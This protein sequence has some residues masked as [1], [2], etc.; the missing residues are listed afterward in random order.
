MINGLASEF[1]PD[2]PT[3]IAGEGAGAHLALEVQLNATQEVRS[4]LKGQILVSP[5]LDPDSNDMGAPD[6]Q[7]Q[8]ISRSIIRWCWRQ[9]MPSKSTRDQLLSYPLQRSQLVGLP[10]TLI[11]TA[12]FDPVGRESEVLGRELLATSVEVVTRRFEGQIHGF[13]RCLMLPAGELAFQEFISFIRARLPIRGGVVAQRQME[14]K[15]T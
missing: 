12:E 5:V 15:G 2:L 9:Y 8:L 3:F 6:G 1:D 7:D 4:A 13:F 10:A 11:M 14:W